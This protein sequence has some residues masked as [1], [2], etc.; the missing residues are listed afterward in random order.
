[1][2]CTLCFQILCTAG[3]S[4]AAARE[5]RQLPAGVVLLRHT[6]LHADLLALQQKII[7]DADLRQGT[8]QRAAN[9]VGS[10]GVTHIPCRGM[11]PDTQ[12]Q[13]ASVLQF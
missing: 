2:P 10:A 11:P 13:E 8:S 5:S 1:M 6:D 4:T 12:K 3:C 9:L 7:A